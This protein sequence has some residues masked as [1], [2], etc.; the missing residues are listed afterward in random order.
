MCHV[1][2]VWEVHY[3]G[4]GGFCIV[5]IQSL[6]LRWRFQGYFLRKGGTPYPHMAQ[7]SDEQKD[8]ANHSTGRWCAGL[9]GCIFL[10]PARLLR[11][12]SSGCNLIASAPYSSE[13]LFTSIHF[14]Q[15]CFKFF[16]SKNLQWS[17]P[18]VGVHA[19]KWTY[20]A[21]WWIDCIED[22]KHVLIGFEACSKGEN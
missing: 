9:W 22:N 20:H 19:I 1:S 5:R 17:Y 6:L 10:I 18:A 7:G 21:R 14:E 4:T 2:I 12:G 15:L 8:L 16:L 13:R 11:S 3:K